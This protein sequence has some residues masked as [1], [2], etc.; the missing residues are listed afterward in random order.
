MIARI[1]RGCARGE[2]ADACAASI[3]DRS[4]AA[5]AAAPGNRGA[6][7]LRRDDEDGRTRF[8]V[9]TLWES[10]AAAAA[11]AG[12]E[13][14]LIDGDPLVAHYELAGGCTPRSGC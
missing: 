12:E 10:P 8:V 14:Y 13:R 9:V 11:F 5:Y 2:D 1:W 3:L 7:L 6:W 4:L